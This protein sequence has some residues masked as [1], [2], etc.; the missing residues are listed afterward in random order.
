MDGNKAQRLVLMLELL[1]RPGGVRAAEL[2]SRFELDARSLR[3]YLADLRDI[4]VPI[5][6]RGRGD[7][8]VLEVEPRWRRSGVRLTLPEVLSLHF[9]RRLFTFLE[10]TTFASDMDGALERLEPAI[11]R[12]HAELSRQLDRTFIAVPEP[13]KEYGGE[14]SEI[15]D[16]LVTALLYRHPVDVRYRRADEIIRTYRLHPYT[17][18]VYRQGL[19]LLARDVEAGQV[20]TFAVE[21]I[22]ELVRNHRERFEVPA[23]WLPERYL[24]AA[25]GITL[26]PPTPVVV[27][28][29]PAVRTLVQERRWHA[30]ATTRRRPDGWLEVHMTVAVTPELISW[31]L[32]FGRDARAVSPPELCARIG[33]EARAMAAAYPLDGGAGAP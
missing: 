13:A 29:S 9:G 12:A 31:I 4:D 14:T 20:K 23:D 25:F 21:R 33:Q 26:G 15:I 10:G 5:V 2:E 11:A 18:A 1:S 17:L 28:F 19:Y 32:S 27:A 7:E 6:D 8:R 30:S 3:R 22:A 24:A 16:D